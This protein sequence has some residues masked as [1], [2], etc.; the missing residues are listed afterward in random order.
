ML[1][2]KTENRR[3]RQTAGS[4]LLR[5]V[6]SL[7]VGV[8]VLSA[9]V[10][11]ALHLPPV[12]GAVIRWGLHKVETAASAQIE[13][14]SYRWWPLSRLYLLKVKVQSGGKQVLE[15]EEAVLTYKFS[16]DWPYLIP[17]EL[18][19][20][21]PIIQV[22]KDDKGHWLL[23]EASNRPSSSEEGPPEKTPWPWGNLPSP[24]IKIVSG[25]IFGLQN[26]QQI[27]AVRDITGTIPLQ[28]VSD[29][30][31]ARLGI[32]LGQWQEQIRNG[33]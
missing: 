13:L 31:R 16:F 22:E 8:I 25:T 14:T 26:G 29:K 30:G 21:K 27:L 18:Q 20:Q 7:I 17:I 11:L 3:Q 24:Q 32:D 9:F 23:P 2:Q 6:V 15:C 10:V 33:H 28:M 1:P 19:F 4:F 12:Q 5:L